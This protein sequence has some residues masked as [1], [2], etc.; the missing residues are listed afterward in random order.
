MEYGWIG[1][2]PVAAEKIPPRDQDTAPLEAKSRWLR[3]Q[4]QKHDGV[5]DRAVN[6]SH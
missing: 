6:I 5:A 1:A 2:V 3:V 4:G